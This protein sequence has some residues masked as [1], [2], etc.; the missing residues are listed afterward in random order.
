MSASNQDEMCGECDD[1][2][3]GENDDYVYG[4]GGEGDGGGGD[5]ARASEASDEDG[6]GGFVVPECPGKRRR[7]TTVTRWSASARAVMV[8]ELGEGVT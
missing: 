1:Y 8:R 3:D 4:V 5:E 6:G 7:I 2:L